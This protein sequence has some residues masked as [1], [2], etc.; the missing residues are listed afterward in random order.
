MK[1]TSTKDSLM[2]EEDWCTQTAKYMKANGIWIRRKDT[3][4]IY[5]KMVPS[6][7]VS[8]KKIFSMGKVVRNGQINRKTL[9]HISHFEGTY[10]Q[11]KKTG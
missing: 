8:G 10:Y 6:M 3:V 2:E 1:V 5:T 4:Y 9:S 11:G 7:K